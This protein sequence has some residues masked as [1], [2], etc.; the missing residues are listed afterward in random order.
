[1]DKE[2]LTRAQLP[3][4][5]ARRCCQGQKALGESP[6]GLQQHKEQHLELL[7]AELGA[8]IR[9]IEKLMDKAPVPVGTHSKTVRG[10]KEKNL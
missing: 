9:E 2:G 10:F 1:M 6:R 3:G 7:L 4:K 8:V 5:V